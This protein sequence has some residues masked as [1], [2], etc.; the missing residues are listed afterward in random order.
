MF[1]LITTGY[2]FRFVTR[3]VRSLSRRFAHRIQKF[4]TSCLPPPRVFSSVDLRLSLIVALHNVHLLHPVAQTSTILPLNSLLSFFVRQFH[5]TSRIA[6]PTFITL[7]QADSPTKFCFSFC[8]SNQLVFDKMTPFT[9]AL[10]RQRSNAVI[11]FQFDLCATVGLPPVQR[12]FPEP[13]SSNFNVTQRHCKTLFRLD[14]NSLLFPLPSSR[15]P[16][17]FP[18]PRTSNLK[19]SL[20]SELRSSFH[21]ALHNVHCLHAVAPT[22]TLLPLNSFLS[23]FVRQFH[24]TSRTAL[25]T[26]ITL[27]QADSPT[28]FFFSF[29][30]SNQLALDKMTPFSAALLRQRFN[31]VIVSIQFLS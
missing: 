2:S 25:P 20:L 7:F 30:S 5:F 28:K 8:S 24:F 27:F 29:F 4:E 12:R 23:S 13:S 10:F 3:E 14:S 19:N 31:A 22:P 1:D 9:V 6:L 18:S 26:F 11:Q 17:N 21:V 15:R 16:I